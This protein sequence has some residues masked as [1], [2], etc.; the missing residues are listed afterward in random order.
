MNRW[1]QENAQSMIYIG[2]ALRDLA[3]NKREKI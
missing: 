2:D 3:K 1:D